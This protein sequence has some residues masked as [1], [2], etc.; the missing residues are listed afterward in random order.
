[1]IAVITYDA[2]HRKTQDLVY[3]LIL[4]GYTAI[5]LIVIPW[6]ERANYLPIYKHRP[7]N[8]VSITIDEFCV[9]LNLK[10]S[11]LEIG[12]INEYLIKNNFKHILIGGAGILPEDL[13]KN[14]KIINSHPGYLPNLKGLDALKWAIYYKQ[15]IGVTTHYISDKADEGELI[16]RVQ[17]PLYFED[18]FHNL[19]YRIYETEI[20]MLVN[21]IKMIEN[22]KTILEALADDTFKANR[23]MPHHLENIMLIRF[24]DLRKNALSFKT[25]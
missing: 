20:D 6:A 16:E 18:T 3:K 2:A 17:V 19:S 12:D 23:R 11:R 7:S 8:K 13:S 10:F 9:R 4:N 25:I 15:P 1:M 14:H 22:N 24:E 21:A 5:Q